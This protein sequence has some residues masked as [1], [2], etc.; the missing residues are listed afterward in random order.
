MRGD[1]WKG[2]ECAF[3]HEEDILNKARAKAKAQPKAGKGKGKDISAVPKAPASVAVAA[4]ASFVHTATA[5]TSATT[6]FFERVKAGVCLVAR[7][8]LGLPALM[9]AATVIAAVST[10]QKGSVFEIERI[11]DS[12]AGESLGSLTAWAAQG[13]QLP[14]LKQNIRKSKSPLIFETGGGDQDGAVSLGVTSDVIG[15]QSCYLLEKCPLVSSMGK[16]Q[17]ADDA[18]RLAP[19]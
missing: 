15:G 18:I 3:S 9:K 8:L 12:G 10:S 16:I 6:P 4:G 13:V 19:Q 14:R 1:C 7:E 5:E 17:R 2:E 11:A